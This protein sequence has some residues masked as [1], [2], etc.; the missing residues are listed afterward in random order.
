MDPF[1]FHMQDVLPATTP[2]GPSL[3]HVRAAPTDA[4]RAAI[5]VRTAV[6]LDVPKVLP[7]HTM[8][9][10]PSWAPCHCMLY[11]ANML[12]RAFRSCERPSLLSGEHLNFLTLTRPE[13]GEQLYSSC[14]HLSEL[15]RVSTYHTLIRS[16]F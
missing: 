16:F 1:G 4:P 6:I 11:R 13:S 3:E 2:V 8:H 12:Y 9:I 5:E 14:E 15:I 7:F 10:W